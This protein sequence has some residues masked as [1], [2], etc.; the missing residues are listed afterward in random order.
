[1]TFPARGNG[2]YIVP[3]TCD[4]IPCW[5]CGATIHN[6]TNQQVKAKRPTCGKLKCINKRSNVL[7]PS[8]KA[9]KTA[10]LLKARG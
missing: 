4:P 3:R 6:P 9:N 10:R 7:T 2:Y 1:M 8:A 5:A